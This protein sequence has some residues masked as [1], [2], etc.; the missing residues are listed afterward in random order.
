[1]LPGAVSYLRV[2]SKE[3]TKNLSIPVQESACREY[4]E[5]NGLQLLKVFTELGESAKTADR[6]ALKELLIY[7]RQNQAR[8]NY[9]V[10]YSIDRFAR[11]LHDHAVLRRLLMTFGISLRSVTQPIDDS[12]TGK[13]LE[14]VL[15]T[16]AEFDNV[17]KREKVIAG[18]RA[19]AERGRWPWGA[20]IG[21]V[22]VRA[23]RGHTLMA[24][25]ERAELVRHAF[26]LYATGLY[27]K[28]AVLEMVT[29]KGLRTRRGRPL[30]P[31]TF[32]KTLTNP[33]YAG[34]ISI[35]A[36]GIEVPGCFD[37]LID[38]DTFLR[39]QAL[40][41]GRRVILRPHERAN[42]DFPLRQFVRCEV[43]GRPLTGS[44]SKG[45][46]R[47]YAYYHCPV[48]RCRTVN[49][50]KA[51]LES[52]FLE[53]LS[54]LR[55]HAEFLDLF[56][57]I[58]LDVWKKR[59]AHVTS[60]RARLQRHVTTLKARKQRLNDAFIYEQAVDRDTYNDQLAQLNE[61][62]AMAELDLHDA[63]LEEL[64]VEGVLEFARHLLLNAAR[65]WSEASLAQRDRLQRTLFPEGL[66]FHPAHGFRTGVTCSIFNEM[67]S[68]VGANRAEVTGT[69][70]EV[71]RTG[72]SISILTNLDQSEGQKSRLVSPT[73]FE[74]VLLP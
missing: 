18:M 62:L 29:R 48:A 15:A 37:P 28:N 25:P 47:R 31:Q 39:V 8:V 30:S 49:I 12:S 13:L 65:M 64:D 58:V 27:G 45:R 33:V 63:R 4:I 73:G 61:S 60:A 69:D 19:A 59:Q 3:Q 9:V 14:G 72:L 53:L 22:Q 41:A 57:A 7:C 17:Q 1:M 70:P 34:R 35:P 20:P 21:Y 32:F 42:A 66:T 55:P 24:D 68:M 36:W 16:F 50:A 44:W 38:E 54:E 51:E 52:A 10:V 71:V 23:Q 74:P 46:S 40:L 6:T 56:S 26:E 5:K 43:C 67:A 11:D 2:S